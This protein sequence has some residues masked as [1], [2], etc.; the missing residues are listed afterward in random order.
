MGMDV[1]GRKPTAPEGVYFRRNIWGWHPL[2]K[3]CTT[4]AP[5]ETRKCKA[6]HDNEEDGLNAVQSVALANRLQQLIADGTVA[7]YLARQS[8]L[9]P[10][11]LGLTE[12]VKFASSLGAR[13]PTLTVDLQDVIEFIAFL[14]ACGG[15][16]IC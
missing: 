6:W 2:A 3:L 13:I 12:V 1:Y 7:G 9:D 11:E 16:N 8:A 10:A 4:L 5:A 14:R 15:F